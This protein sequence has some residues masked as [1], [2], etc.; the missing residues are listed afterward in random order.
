MSNQLILKIIKGDD[1]ILEATFFQDEAETI[2]LLLTGSVVEATVKNTNGNV[3]FQFLE[4]NGTMIITSNKVT[5]QLSE[6]HT[7]LFTWKEGI[8]EL[9]VKNPTSK[10]IRVKGKAVVLS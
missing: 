6:T 10:D 2:P 7:S 5:L 1:Y 4:S 9:V 8:F 3:L